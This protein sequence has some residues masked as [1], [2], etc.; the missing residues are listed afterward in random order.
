MTPFTSLDLGLALVLGFLVGVFWASVRSRRDARDRPIA[1]IMA[2]VLEP[3]YWWADLY[4][5]DGRPSHAKLAYTA[6]LVVALAG[7]VWIG[8]IDAADGDVSVG[9]LGYVVLVLA[10]ALGKQVFNHLWLH[11]V[12]KFGDKAAAAIAQRRSGPVEVPVP[13]GGTAP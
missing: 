5:A 8:K 2:S 13:P 3:P 11:L 4:G 12:A 1:R 6:A 7:M 10:F 9:F